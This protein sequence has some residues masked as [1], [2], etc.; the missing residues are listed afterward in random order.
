MRRERTYIW[1][2][3]GALALGTFVLWRADALWFAWVLAFT[4]IRAVLVFLC[5]PGRLV[6]SP[7]PYLNDAS[8]PYWSLGLALCYLAAC[9]MIATDRLDPLF[10]WLFG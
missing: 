10:A 4:A 1:C 8:W 5:Q 9:F 6:G 7:Y 2:G 3:R